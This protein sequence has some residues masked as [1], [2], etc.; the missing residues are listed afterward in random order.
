MLHSHEY[1]LADIIPGNLGKPI[2]PFVAIHMS[3]MLLSMACWAIKLWYVLHLQIFCTA[4][5]KLFKVFNEDFLIDGR[6]LISKIN[7][8]VHIHTYIHTYI[9]T[10]VH[11]YIHTHTQTYIHTYIH[12]YIP[13]DSNKQFNI[14]FVLPWFIFSGWQ[15][16]YSVLFSKGFYF[17]IFRRDPSLRK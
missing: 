11:T 1:K 13:K 8:N 7:Y 16:P 14:Q 3:R 15:I 2:E 6:C 5:S 4:I 17:R 12:T 9:R 10:Y